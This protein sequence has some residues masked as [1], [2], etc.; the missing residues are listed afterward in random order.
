M[1][2]RNGL[3]SAKRLRKHGLLNDERDEQA[4]ADS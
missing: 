3:H 4:E 2:L 1:S